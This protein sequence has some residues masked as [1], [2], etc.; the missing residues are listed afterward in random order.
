[1]SAG[2]RGGDGRG[3]GG[4]LEAVIFDW[5]G[6]ITPWHT[7]D[8]H[9]QWRV[10]ARGAGAIG[11]SQ[12]ELADALARAEESAWAAGRA[13]GVSARLSDIL[14]SVGLLDDDP[15]THAGVAAYRQFWE[16]HTFTHPDIAGLWEGLRDDGIRVGVL[17]NTIW[18]RGYHRGIFERDEVVHL[19]DADV[20]SSETPWVKPRREIFLAAA[21]ALGVEPGACVYVGDRS[22]EDVHGP[23]SAGMRAIWIPHSNIPESQQVSHRAT[24]DAVAHELAQVADIV[25]AWN[26]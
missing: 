8:V 2:R 19:V 6:T 12:T 21:A 14:A 4:A 9:E 1:M 20:Y 24:P 26:A 15:R 5:G 13:D 17:S 25:A 16:P 3:G 23:Q 10:F 22:Y 18:D 7:V 11:C